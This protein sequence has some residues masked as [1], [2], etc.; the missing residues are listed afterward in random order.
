[1]V[2]PIEDLRAWM[3]R[4]AGLRPSSVRPL[5]GDGSTR[6][7]FRA[8][9]SGWTRIVIANPL[10]LNR[11]RPDEN[12]GYLAVSRYLKRRGIPVP[13]VHAADLERGFLLLEDLGD[14]RLY[15]RVR[16]S[17]WEAGAEALGGVYEEAIDLLAA[18]QSMSP[19]R[20]DPAATPNEAYTERFV[21]EREARYFHD[22]L[23]VGWA[24]MSGCWPAIEPECRHLAE[25]AVR[26]APPVFMH[27][28]YQSRNLMFRGGRLVV[29]DFQGARLGPR[30]YDLAA[31]LLDPYVA[32]PAEIRARLIER[33]RRA[34]GLADLA[35]SD[36]RLRWSANAANRMM[37]A[38][39]AFAKLGGRMGRPGFIEHIPRGLAH[40]TEVL[41]LRGDAPRL[42]A[43]VGE[44]RARI[45]P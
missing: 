25:D 10:P 12:E 16:G 39:G 5:A 2:D 40:L 11:P 43:L 26:A 35:E 1:M 27:R 8:E 28:D 24:G 13:E 23:V 17:G 7:I 14:E 42:V 9:G 45:D 30:E 36:W 19:P 6:R 44:L 34:A 3:E 20:F 38:L 37:Q 29:I 41:E 22:E 32:V 15:E 31:L 4:T 18:M 33:Y 21:L